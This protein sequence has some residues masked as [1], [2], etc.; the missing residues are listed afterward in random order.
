MKVDK[1]NNTLAKKCLLNSKDELLGYLDSVVAKTKFNYRTFGTEIE[2]FVIDE[3]ID[4][5][6]KDGF[7]K[8]K[9]DYRRAKN[10]NEF[11]DFVL[12]S[13]PNLATEIKS[14]SHSKKQRNAWVSCRNSNN[15]MGTLNKWPEKLKEFGGNNIYYIFIEYDFRDDNQKIVDVKIAPFYKFL[16][17]NSDGVLRYREKDGN[18]RPKDFNQES[19][20]NSLEQFSELLIRT[21][22]YRSKRIIEKHQYNVGVHKRILRS[23]GFKE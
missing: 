15:D 8:S 11:P 4:I 2:D 13:D 10:K 6:K 19:L 7:I 23:A 5:F 17:L 1:K 14:G 21:H 3:L 20:I 9:K 22:I 12:C 18:L 16:A